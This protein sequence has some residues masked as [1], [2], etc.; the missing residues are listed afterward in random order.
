MRDVRTAVLVLVMLLLAACGGD[1]DTTAAGGDAEPED[2]ATSE[3]TDGPTEAAEEPTEAEAAAGATVAVTGSE[4][5]EILVDADGVTLYLFTPD[6]RGDSTCY[7]DCAQNWPP[8]EGPAEAGDGAD[9]AL[10]DTVER[11]DG[12]A[13]VTYNGWPLYYFAGDSAAGDT[14][15][16]GVGDIWYVVDPSG[17]AVRETAAGGE[18]RGY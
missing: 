18:E 8:L 1:A 17:D 9:A 13:Q 3:A 15:G 6:E 16:Q 7:D 12:T 14:N 11:E 4:L 2:V 5:G 10:L